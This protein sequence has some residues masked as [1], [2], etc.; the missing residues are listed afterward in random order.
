MIDIYLKRTTSDN[1]D[2]RLLIKE[3]D[4]DLRQRNG[5]VMD[6]YDQHNIIEQI[7]TV[8][9]AYAG[10]EPAGC[11][12]FKDYDAN[13]VEVKRM[14]VRPAYRGNKI[15]AKILTEL[16]AWARELGYTSTVLETGSRQT[17]ALGLYQKSGYVSIPKYGPY[18][19]LP[20]SICFQKTI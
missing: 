4:A 15:S 14:Y 16:E 13:T 2:F 17:E 9:I 7:D 6:I 1:A 5:E 12:C 10:D 18:I 20:D 3:L 19:D 11:G 8:V